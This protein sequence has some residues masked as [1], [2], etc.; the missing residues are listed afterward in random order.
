MKT[1]KLRDVINLYR[2]ATTADGEGGLAAPVYTL[3][4]TRLANVS[5]NSMNE[6]LESGKEAGQN[7]YTITF[8]RDVN[9]QLSKSLR[10]RWNN[11]TLN[12]TSITTDDY[13]FYVNASGSD[14]DVSAL[15]VDKTQLI[16]AQDA[17]ALLVE[18]DYTPESWAVL[19]FV[20]ALPEATQ[21]QADFKAFAINNSISLLVSV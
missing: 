17:A 15:I 14:S 1:G 5:N 16:I 6:S 19:V 21:Q 7:S 4:A 18:E 11:Q 13:W 2:V 9:E 20:L 8:R 3:A 10:I 12:I